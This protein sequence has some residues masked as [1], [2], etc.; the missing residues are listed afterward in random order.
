MPAATNADDRSSSGG[1][2]TEVDAL[3]SQ[4]FIRTCKVPVSKVRLMTTA[5]RLIRQTSIEEKMPESVEGHGSQLKEF[6]PIVTLVDVSEESILTGENARGLWFRAV[7]GN[8][9]LAALKRRDVEYGTDTV[10][11]VRV[12]RNMGEH[13]ERV[14]L[15]NRE[16]CC[17]Y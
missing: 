7:D 8:C 4:S 17:L 16:Y 11:S 5:E 15:A 10:V 6:V 12:H 3:F 1:E 13:A 14:F 9:R 2:N